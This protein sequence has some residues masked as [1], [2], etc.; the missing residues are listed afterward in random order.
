MYDMLEY[1]E[2][3]A[4]EDWHLDYKKKTAERKMNEIIKK[5]E[6]INKFTPD[7]G[8]L[9]LH[10]DIIIVVYDDMQMRGIENV[11]LKNA[12]YLG[13]VKST[14]NNYILKVNPTTAFFIDKTN[15]KQRGFLRGEAY[16]VSPMI[17][18]NLDY[19]KGNLQ[20]VKRVKKY[21]FLLDQDYPVKNGTKKPSV[22][23]FIWMGLPSYWNDRPG[24]YV[25]P[26]TTPQGDKSKRYYEHI[27]QNHS[28]IWNPNNHNFM[29]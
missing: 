21:F 16:A 4:D 18:A 26:S 19:Y 12:K 17:L 27:V 15:E 1:M 28:A 8:T 22:E 5:L 25:G 6:D 3:L 24:M 13:N 7:F 2:S 10:K 11:F 9:R 20:K 29:H 23:A 14:G